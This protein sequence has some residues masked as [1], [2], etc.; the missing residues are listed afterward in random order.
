ML[1]ASLDL[2]N[3]IQMI[4]KITQIACG[5]SKIKHLK[6]TAVSF[7]KG[8]RIT[9]PN[10]E[11]KTHEIENPLETFISTLAACETAILRAVAGQAQVK[12]GNINFTRIES[13]YDLGHWATGGGINNKLNEI[14][15]DV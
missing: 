11:N 8:L 13:S 7:P 10:I 1:T 9:Y 12:L 6:T 3:R 2:Y 15:L 14:F 4:R 5:F